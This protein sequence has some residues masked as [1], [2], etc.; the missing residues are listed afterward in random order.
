MPQRVAYVAL[1]QFCEQ[2]DQ[3]KRILVAAGFDVRENKLGR[4]LKE[5]EMPSLLRE[6]DVVLAGVEPYNRELLRALPRLR[7]ISRCGI[8]TDSIDLEAARERRVAVL[9]TAE[10]VARPVAEMTLAMILVLAR[11]IP[12]LGREMGS[13]LWRKRT[14]NLISEWTIGLVGFGRIGREVERLLR[15]FGANLL[16]CDPRI[17]ESDLP[18]GVRLCR[19]EELLAQSDLVSV[20]AARRA[21]EGP[22]FGRKEFSLMKAE[23]YFINTARGYL[24]DEEALLAALESGRLAGAALDV[25][26][27]EPYAGP[28]AKLPQ[29]LCTPHVST[30]T[31]ASRLAMELRCARNAVEF[32][33]KE[34]RV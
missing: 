6:A 3:P 9:T 5:E 14:G 18:L 27:E 7:C 32:F 10:E 21:E 31:V 22:L 26:S 13:G 8:G 28:L 33:F 2:D 30:L 17:V 25:F 4:R 15:P 20:H 34:E 19:F 16:V 12:Q 1:Q 23:S 11:R 24:V 29:V